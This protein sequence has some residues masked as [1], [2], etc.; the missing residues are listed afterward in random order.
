MQYKIPIQIENEDTIFLGLSLRQLAIIMV[1]WGVA[2]SLFQFLQPRIGTF[3][4]ILAVP[5][6]TIGI[7][8]ALVRIAEMTFMPLVLNAIRLSLNGKSRPWSQWTDSYSE[9]EIGYVMENT[10]TTQTGTTKE[11]LDTIINKNDDFSEKLKKL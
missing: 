2:Y 9:L 10:T 3:A 4:L 7:V 11:S 8:I 5:I 6:A 1:F